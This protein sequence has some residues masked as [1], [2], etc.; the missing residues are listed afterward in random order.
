MTIRSFEAGD[1]A[2]QVSIYNEAA[3]DLPKFKPATLDELRRRLRGKDFDPSTRFFA[4]SNG[5]PMAYVTF[6]RNGRVS[7]PWCRKGFED[8]ADPLLLHALEAM[9]QRGLARAFAAYRGD[10]PTVGD[11]FRRHGFEQAREMINYVLDLADMPTPAA[12]PGVPI[13]PVTPE[14]LPALLALSPG[15]LH[16]SD[17]TGLEQYLLHN[18]YFPPDAAFVLR[19][20]GDNQ[21]AALGIVVANPAYANPKQV[22]A[23][24]PCFRL[25]AFGTEDQQTKRLNGLFSVLVP[26][27]RDVNPRGL[28]L[29]NHVAFRL[30]ETDVECVAAQVPSDVPHLARFYKQYFRKQGSFPIYEKTLG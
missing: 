1:D 9:K 13:T 19:N 11:F 5:R 29:L 22:D 18:P 23:A 12:R 16:V 3:A 24:M 28:D 20:R 6:H 2:A 17:A 27:G 10:W 30:T 7:Y 15:V 21:P 14:D 8:L 25:G 26:D 4:L